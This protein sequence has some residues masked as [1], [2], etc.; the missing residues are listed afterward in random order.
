MQSPTMI[1][2]KRVLMACFFADGFKGPIKQCSVRQEKKDRNTSMNST[3]LTEAPRD[4]VG[5]TETAKAPK[6]SMSI[7]QVSSTIDH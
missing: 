2:S 4:F 7:L 1:A 5:K 3:R 6:N